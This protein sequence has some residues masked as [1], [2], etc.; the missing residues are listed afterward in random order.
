MEARP[1]LITSVQRALHLLD[2]VGEYNRP[3]QAKTLARRT[4]QPL[5]TTYHLL[6]TLVHEGYLRRVDGAGYVLGDR[7]AALSGTGA[8]TRTAR[9]RTILQNLH[10][11]LNAAAYLSILDDGE[12]RLV[13]VVD[14]KKAPRVDLWV[15]FHDAAH[16]TALGKAVLSTLEERERLDY[17][18]THDL[19][20]LTPRTVTSRK[21]LLRE[22]DQPRAYA[23]DREEYAL[24]TGCVA[25]SVP[26]TAITAAIAVSVPTNQVQRIVEQGAVLRRAARLVALAAAD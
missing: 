5:P 14:S 21:L 15:G 23:V 8:A 9:F 12:I 22:L 18:G 16:A 2:A 26:S 25:A 6:R 20:D 13:D 1:T 7:V 10:D 17:L 4:G 11:E 3:V 24:G 19:P